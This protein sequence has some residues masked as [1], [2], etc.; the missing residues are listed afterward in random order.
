MSREA[1]VLVLR[2]PQG[3]IPWGYS[4]DFILER[5]NG[6]TKGALTLSRRWMRNRSATDTNAPDGIES[7]H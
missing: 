7:Q 3:E 1:H 2:E 4:P 6:T 5:L